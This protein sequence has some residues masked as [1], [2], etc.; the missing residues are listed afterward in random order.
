VFGNVL[1]DHCRVL[2]LIDDY[3]DQV[4]ETRS[5]GVQTRPQLGQKEQNDEKVKYARFECLTMLHTP[6]TMYMELWFAL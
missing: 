5:F 6:F 3:N 4:M 2:E 1:C